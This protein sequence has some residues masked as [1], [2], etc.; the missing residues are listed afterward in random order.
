[1]CL[2]CPTCFHLL[3]GIHRVHRLKHWHSPHTLAVV[4]SDCN[5]LRAIAVR[6]CSIVCHSRETGHA[7]NNRRGH[8][9]EKKNC[10]KSRFA[11][12]GTN[13]AIP[14]TA[15]LIFWKPFDAD[16]S[17]WPRS[18]YDEFFSRVDKSAFAP[19]SVIRISRDRVRCRKPDERTSRSVAI[20]LYLK[21]NKPKGSLIERTFVG[22]GV[23]GESKENQR[24]RDET[25]SWTLL[26][27]L[28]RRC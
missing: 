1:M 28:D 19:F 12:V 14:G 17:P 5:L 23:T 22:L 7:S 24:R 25:K 15:W 2:L 10:L 20:L 8:P 27:L 11:S 4:R 26:L 16:D 3:T 21:R 9:N 18:R 6:I 13:N